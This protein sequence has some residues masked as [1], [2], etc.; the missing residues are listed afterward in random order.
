LKTFKLCGF[1]DMKI[2]AGFCSTNQRTER[3]RHFFNSR[4]TVLLQNPQ[5]VKQF[6]WVFIK[7]KEKIFVL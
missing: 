7:M 4:A 6:E 2:I 3:M 1:L 5:N